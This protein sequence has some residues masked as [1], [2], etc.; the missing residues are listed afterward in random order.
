MILNVF[1]I[2]L[3]YNKIPTG[4]LFLT[5]FVSLGIYIIYKLR[6]IF[7]FNVIWGFLIV[8]FVYVLIGYFSEKVKNWLKE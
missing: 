5:I 1:E 4:D 2:D 8:V 7:P 6:K 3:V